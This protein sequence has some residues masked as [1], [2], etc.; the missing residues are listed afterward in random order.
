MGAFIDETGNRYNRLLVISRAE[1]SSNRRTKWLCKC[2][3]GNE[4]IVTAG[5]LRGGRTCSC[6]CKKA[7]NEIGH[8][9]GKLVVLSQAST[10]PDGRLKWLCKCD[11]GNESIVSGVNLRAGDTKSCGCLKHESHGLIDET[12]NRYGKLVVL[13]RAKDNKSNRP[14]W[15]CQCD[16][17]RQTIV[18]VGNL[19]G[20]TTISCGC[21]RNQ[22]IRSVD[23]AGKR[24]GRL[25]VIK[26]AGSL[27][28]G[29]ATWLC[30]CDCGNETIVT[31]PNLRKGTSQ[32]CGC[33]GRLSKGE[34]NFNRLVHNM[35]RGAK[36]R[37]YEWGLNY[38]QLKELTKQDC[39]YCGAEPNHRV[40]AIKSNGEYV[41]N[42]L[43]RVDNSKGYIIGN[44]VPCCSQCNV[45]KST[46]SAHNF[47]EWI[48]RVYEHSTGDQK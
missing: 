31:G 14:A 13:S 48:G 17:G 21:F 43:D 44:V 9:Y 42:G 4:A 27:K 6:G 38:D 24:H 46:H 45:A 3:C 32:S 34:A 16:C 47:L 39:H 22:I 7:P 2:D 37:G 25:T 23:E 20:G 36:N 5:D 12:G 30:K 40:N 1:N 11:C 33:L 18:G 15:L 19:R 26:K 41:Y 29:P 8:R 10:A 35:M 28:N